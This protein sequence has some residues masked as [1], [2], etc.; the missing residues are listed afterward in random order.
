MCD[1]P[2]R[3]SAPVAASPQERDIEDVSAYPRHRRRFPGLANQVK[4]ARR[5]VARCLAGS[6]GITTA[7]LLTSE[8]VTNAVTHSASGDSGGKFDVTVVTG[9]HWAR[10]EVGDRGGPAAPSAQHRDPFDITEHGRGLD[11]VEALAH[12]WGSTSHPS[13]LGRLV[14]FELVWEPE[15]ACDRGSG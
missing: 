2:A 5:F 13:T 7:T 6:P 8:L 10:I 3:S 12:R 14:W 4:H 9:P 15:A 11:L 1:N